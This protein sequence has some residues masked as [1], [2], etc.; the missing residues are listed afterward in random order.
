MRYLKGLWPYTQFL[1]TEPLLTEVF[2]AATVTS[3]RSNIQAAATAVGIDV[4]FSYVLLGLTSRRPG[5]SAFADFETFAAWL[6]QSKVSSGAGIGSAPVLHVPF[7]E[8]RVYWR[9]SGDDGKFELTL[10]GGSK[11]AL[12]EGLNLASY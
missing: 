12:V 10:S 2:T 1:S 8:C 9:F 3:M 5:L 6:Q 7:Y 11:N 4:M